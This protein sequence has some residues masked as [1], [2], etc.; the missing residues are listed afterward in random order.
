MS[1][2]QIF[3]DFVEPGKSQEYLVINFSPTS[4]PLQQRWR[5]NGLSADFLA[6]YW[7]TFFPVD[8]HFSFSKQIEIKGAINYIANELLENAM[9]F[10]YQ[11]P[12]YQVTISLYLSKNE[13][14]FYTCNSINPETIGEFQDS[15]KKLLTEDAAKLYVHQLE[16]NANEKNGV[17]SHM[18]YLTMIHD[19]KAHLAWKFETIQPDPLLII[20][21]TMVRLVINGNSNC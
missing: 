15:I 16:S 13:L 1:N 21:T 6:D 20:L 3:G 8:D 14:R 12:D 2:N 4:M 5:N 10:S 11:S 17:T 19:Y 18:G 9:K 7:I